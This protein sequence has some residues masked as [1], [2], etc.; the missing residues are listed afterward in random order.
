MTVDQDGAD[1]FRSQ[2]F[3]DGLAFSKATNPRHEQ[4]VAFVSRDNSHMM[5]KKFLFVFEG[6]QRFHDR[7][8]IRRA[9]RFEAIDLMHI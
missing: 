5:S 4:S 8:C 9:I 3:G 7:H 6:S 2:S 1:A